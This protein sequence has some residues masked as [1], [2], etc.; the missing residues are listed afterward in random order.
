MQNLIINTVFL[1]IA[2]AVSPGIVA[3]FQEEAS[4]KFTKAAESTSSNSLT[5]PEWWL[6]AVE[7]ISYPDKLALQTELM[8]TRFEA[9][10]ALDSMISQ[11]TREFFGNYLSQR[12]LEEISSAKDFLRKF[13]VVNER[14]EVLAI[15]LS[16]TE[17][18]KTKDAKPEIKYRGFAQVEFSEGLWQRRLIRDRLVIA[19]GLCGTILSGLATLTVFL[20]LNHATKGMYAG[21]LQM[22]AGVAFVFIMLMIFW[23]SRFVI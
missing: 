4:S 2:L 8:K 3:A 12:D 5:T 18:S 16:P 20:H 19:L 15:Q 22:A 6:E 23:I 9:E 1:L 14:R 21:R 17:N 7:K 13:A 10:A 11:A